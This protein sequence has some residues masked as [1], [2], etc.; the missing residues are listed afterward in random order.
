MMQSDEA[1]KA[2]EELLAKWKSRRYQEGAEI[3]QETPRARR[4]I[5]F[6]ALAF[7]LVATFVGLLQIGLAP[8]V[9]V[10]IGGIALF[11]AGI[12]E[13]FVINKEPW[14]RVLL[15]ILIPFYSLY[16][17]FTRWDKM[18]KPFIIGLVGAVILVAGIVPTFMQYKGE[19]EDVFVEFMEAAA[20]KDIDAAYACC[21]PLQDRGEVADFIDYNYDCFAG[22]EAVTT[23]S[24]E[25]ASSNGVTQGYI[26]GA[27]IYSGEQRLPFEAWLVKEQGVWKLIGISVSY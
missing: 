26:G 7:V 3:K 1:K 23:S 25:V 9:G 11:V 21:S 4:R 8:I 22:Y 19:L 13:L 12:W 15:Y 2:R 20:I 10:V 6:L 17:T 24:W 16:Y 5:I 18:K 14:S 27:I